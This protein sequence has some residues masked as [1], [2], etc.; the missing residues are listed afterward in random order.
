MIT[1]TST[2]HFVLLPGLLLALF[3]CAVLLLD[4]LF[5]K[6]VK[7][8]GWL[9]GIA[10]SGVGFAS[11][12]SWQQYLYLKAHS[13]TPL[14]AFN[15]A[16]V[17]DGFALFFNGIVLASAAL[18]MLISY[19][20]LEDEKEHHTEYYALV[21][22]AA[23][24]AFFLNGGLDM[25]TIF[26]GLELM[27]VSFYILVGF[28]RTDKRSNEAAMKYLL[29][30]GFSTGFLI[31]GFSIF[32]GLTGSTNLT[33]LAS[34]IPARGANDPLLYLAIV[35]TLVG[36][37]F[38]IG[39]APFH[40]WAPDTYEGA[41]TTVTAFLAVAS[42]TA[43]FA[44]L[45]RVMLVG[46]GTAR[47][48]WEPLLTGAAVL[49]LTIG[50]LAAISQSNVKRLLAYS[51]IGHAGYVL[52]GLIA[53]NQTG[54]IGVSIYLLT[55]AFSTIGAFLV[56]IALRRRG[57]AVETIEDLASLG[58]RYPY[59]A[60]LMLLFLMSLAGLP[61]TAGFIGKYY[62]FLS[63][64]ESGKYGLAILGALYVAV[65]L[66][67]YFRLVRSM[68]LTESTEAQVLAP[69]NGVR[70]ALALTGIAT[71]AMGILPEPFLRMAAI[72]LGR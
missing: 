65:S 13:M 72:S 53:G 7:G 36:L 33:A 15:G 27:A 47:E 58:K 14:V 12:Q 10:L 20:Y 41:P 24:G 40:M 28:L 68:F 2:D 55:Y 45:L 26:V 44:L 8:R 30:G 59:Y 38:K 16:L 54:L 18:V 43:S 31:Y 66:Y 32:Y 56:L 1:Y 19:R 29:L 64:V 11:W 61:P 21:L 51:S 3:G 23:C 48:M 50:N 71:I 4:F 60:L 69:S 57:I 9:V 34:V 42:K 5:P 67:Y 70:L 35:T 39:A 62:I 22:F 25:V 17:L 6:D 37:L 46:L 49:S 52:L 63:L